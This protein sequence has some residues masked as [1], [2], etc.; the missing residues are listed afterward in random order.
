MSDRSNG[1]DG[2]DPPR[3]SSGAD[4]VEVKA[5][6]WRARLPTK[7]ADDNEP[8]D[9]R[10]L[11]D[12]LRSDILSIAGFPVKLL[13]E[14]CCGIVR[15]TRALTL[16]G[17][18]RHSNLSEADALRELKAA[19]RRHGGIVVAADDGTPVILLGESIRVGVPG[20]EGRPASNI[21]PEATGT[22]PLVNPAPPR[23]E[24]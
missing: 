8:K 5:A 1:Q 13:K 14:A 22:D 2:C 4:Q 23:T 19:L 11:K 15:V 7:M 3:E 17:I 20:L 18:R 16:G 21:I 12:Q 9:I 10:E 6:F 24:S